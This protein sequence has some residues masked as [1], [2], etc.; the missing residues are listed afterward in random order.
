MG[1]QAAG[2]TGGKRLVLETL[3]IS[4]GW[5]TQGNRPYKPASVGCGKKKVPMKRGPACSCLTHPDLRQTMPSP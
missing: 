5:L 2:G 4:E 3:V 1:E